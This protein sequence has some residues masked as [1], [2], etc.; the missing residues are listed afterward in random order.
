MREK[1]GGGEEG[2]GEE[3]KEKGRGG[4]GR[5]KKRKKEREKIQRTMGG[6]LGGLAP[7]AAPDHCFIWGFR[8]IE[9]LYGNGRFSI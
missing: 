1:G 7:P 9:L 4:G 2:K 5:E 3:E 6:S 8:N